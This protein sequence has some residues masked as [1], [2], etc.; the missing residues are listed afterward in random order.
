MH[1]LNAYSTT[2][3]SISKCQISYG[4][5]KFSH[6]EGEQST[7]ELSDAAF[8]YPPRTDMHNHRLSV[9][10]LEVKFH[11]SCDYHQGET[12]G[13]EGHKKGARGGKTLI[14]CFRGISDPCFHHVCF[15]PL[16]LGGSY[17]RGD[18]LP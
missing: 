16:L 1:K 10:G 5:R 17:S 15:C 8:N 3:S 14:K 11:S 6:M 7:I 18:Y 13:R 9:D 2:Q 4:K 12:Q